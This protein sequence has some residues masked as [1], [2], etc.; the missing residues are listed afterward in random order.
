MFMDFIRAILAAPARI[1]ALEAKIVE[2]EA[3][4]AKAKIT[5]SL[6]LVSPDGTKKIDMV[7]QNNNAGIWISGGTGKPM[8]AIYNDNT[9]GAVVGIWGQAGVD[10]W[11]RG[12]LDVAMSH[13]PAT[14]GTIQLISPDNTLYDIAPG[15]VGKG[16]SMGTN[17]SKF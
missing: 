7:C 9:Q 4:L 11:R 15:T 2:L 12:G 3:A 16:T 10:G 6:T 5:N 14:G 1:D 17:R 13:C 8:V